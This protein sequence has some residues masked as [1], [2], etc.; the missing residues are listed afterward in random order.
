[1]N[2]LTAE[3]GKADETSKTEKWKSPVWAYLDFCSRI[4]FL[5]RKYIHLYYFIYSSQQS[6]QEGITLR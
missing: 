1:M 4:H 5:P 6:C 3:A 2:I